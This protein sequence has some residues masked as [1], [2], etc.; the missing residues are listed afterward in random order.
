MAPRWHPQPLFSPEALDFL[1]VEAVSLPSEHGVGP[2]IAPAGVV[3]GKVPE[4]AAQVGIGVGLGRAMA[5]GGAV[6]PDD[7]ARP[8]LREAEAHLEHVGGSTSL[9]RAYHFP[10]AI[11]FSAT[12]SSA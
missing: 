10:D 1:A 7:S 9:R 3:A 2:A 12:M 4:L 5:L 11:S 6:L 8:P